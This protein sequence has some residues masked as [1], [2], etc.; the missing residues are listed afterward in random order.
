MRREECGEDELKRCSDVATKLANRDWVAL[1]ECLALMTSEVM[2]DLGGSLRSC[3]KASACKEAGLDMIKRMVGCWKRG[4]AWIG[5]VHRIFWRL[6]A[7]I[8]GENRKFDGHFGS[9]TTRLVHTPSVHQM[10]LIAFR[11]KVVLVTV[12]RARRVQGAMT[13]LADE[14]ARDLS[15]TLLETLMSFTAMCETLDVQDDHTGGKG[16]GGQA[17]LRKL[18]LQ[19]LRKI[20]CEKSFHSRSGK[21]RMFG[22][23]RDLLYGRFKEGEVECGGQEGEASEWMFQRYGR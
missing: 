17:R 11:E 22:G 4:K 20:Q 9:C 7:Y 19:P 16:G 8:D 2:E 6:N 5:R 14:E 12:E 3:G 15:D 13:Y 18:F 23:E 1:Y 21:V 10:G